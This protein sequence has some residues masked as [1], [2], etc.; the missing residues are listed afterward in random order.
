MNILAILASTALA[1]ATMVFA[2]PPDIAVEPGSCYTAEWVEIPCPE[3]SDES[4]TPSPDG[5]VTHMQDA[6][7][8]EGVK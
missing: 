4:A 3:L 8:W 1:S 5:R 2:Q 7:E 6:I